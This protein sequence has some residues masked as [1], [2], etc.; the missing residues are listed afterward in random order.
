[1]SAAAIETGWVNANQDY[2]VQAVDRLKARLEAHARD[3]VAEGA[4]GGSEPFAAAAAER[5]SPDLSRAPAGV[6][7]SMR[8][9]ERRS[10][11]ELEWALGA[12]SAL[13]AL[14]RLFMLSP[15]ERDVLVLCAGMELD[16]SVPG[17][18]ARA[19]GDPPLA[20]PTFSLALAALPGAH[21]SALTPA[22]ALRH[23]RLIEVESS[24]SLVNS[25]LRIDERVLHYLAGVQHMDEH[26]IGFVES[27]PPAGALVPSH[28]KVA[29]EIAAVWRNGQ[30]GS[31][32][33]V[34]Q[35]CGSEESE[36]EPTAAAACATLG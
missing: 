31:P 20:Y 34:I 22:A 28:R 29:E 21:W 15:F 24:R 3:R 13:D 5:A 30:R 33:P 27:L 10:E 17:L 1:M 9:A 26:L 11:A 16:A 36:G 23:W 2:L 18:C 6:G 8:A 14:C 32:L 4:G 25:P 7:H 12:P 35:L 19:H